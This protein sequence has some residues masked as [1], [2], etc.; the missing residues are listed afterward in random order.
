[1]LIYTV[2]IYPLFLAMLG[3][4]IN[5]S[6]VRDSIIRTVDIIIPVHNGE[7]EI[8]DKIKNCLELDYPKNSL[9]ICVVSDGSTDRTVEI[10]QSYADQGVQCLSIQERVGKVSAQNI[11]LPKIQSEIIIYTDVSILVQP[12]ALKSIVSNFADESV[13]VVS[14]RDE[15]V[16][17]IRGGLG[18]A[19]YIKYDMWVRKFSSRIG[20]LIGVT[21]GFYAVRRS[22]TIGGWDPAYPPDFYAALRA[23]E[24]RFKVIEDN[25]VVARYY[26]PISDKDE[27]D[28]KVRTITRGMWAL[29]SNAALLNPFRYGMVAIQLISHKLFR[30]LTPFFLLVCLAVSAVLWFVGLSYIY[31]VIFWLLICFY[32]LCTTAYLTVYKMEFGSLV[33][34]IPAMWMLFSVAILLSWKN[35]FM[36]KKIIIWKPT[37]RPSH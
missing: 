33:M 21:G 9:N 26:T 15:I 1:M 8:N 2:A 34:K 35:L 24:A 7:N 29:F 16:Q 13:G 14:C 20:S 18:D 19:I 37:A 11:V 31:F 32:G 25:R 10:A 23:I 27:M 17:D 36:G 3:L 5:R 30:W 28:R 4:L 22:L 6:N 12:D